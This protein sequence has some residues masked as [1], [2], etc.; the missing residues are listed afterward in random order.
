MSYE[1]AGIGEALMSFYC[2][3]PSGNFD[4]NLFLLLSFDC[5][6]AINNDVCFLKG[7]NGDKT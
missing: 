5:L 3:G 7:H 2:C 4:F 6:L 1:F